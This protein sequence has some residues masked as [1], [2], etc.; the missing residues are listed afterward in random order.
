MNN[1]IFKLP[2]TFAELETTAYGYKVINTSSDA[3]KH[4]WLLGGGWIM[5]KL[6]SILKYKEE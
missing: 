6:T 1:P 2:R 5:V 3:I 4:M